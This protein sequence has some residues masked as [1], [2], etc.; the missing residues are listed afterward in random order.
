RRSFGLVAT[1]RLYLSLVTGD[2]RGEDQLSSIR[3]RRGESPFAV[4]FL[5]G[6]G[7]AAELADDRRSVLLRPVGGGGWRLRSDASEMRLEPALVCNDSEPFATQALVLTGDVALGAGVR[8][9]WRLSR[10]AG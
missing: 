5:L 4:R 10:A 6:P 7:V 1:R 3:R 9:R 8:L 2:L